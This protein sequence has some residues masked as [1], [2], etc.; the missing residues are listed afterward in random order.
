MSNNH[1]HHAVRIYLLFL[2]LLFP[3]TAFTQTPPPAPA[4]QTPGNLQTQSDAE[5]RR[6]QER[7]M[8]ERKRLEAAPNVHLPR[9]AAPPR[10]PRRLPRDEAPCF[11]IVQ[12]V[13][14]GDE[15]ER[16]SW[17]LNHLGGPDNADAPLGRCL[18][19][20]GI[21]IVTERAQNALIAA[22]FVT[23]RILTAPQDIASGTLTLTLLPGRV[24]VIRLNDASSP[25]ATLW[26]AVPINPGDILNLRDIEQGLENFKRAPTVDA[27][28]KI[29]PASGA[30]PGWS[31]LIILFQQ[32]N[33][34]RFSLTVDDS[35]GKTTGKYQGSATFSVDNWLTLNDLFYIT[36]SQNLGNT[37]A[38]QQ[39]GSR[40]TV[41]HYSLPL[42]YWL[43]A[44]T[45]NTGGY[46]QNVAGATQTYVY[47]GSSAN[48]EV[49]VSRIVWRDAAGKTTASLKAFQRKS[50]NYIDDTEVEVQRRVVG[51][52]EAG[53]AQ[54]QSFGAATLDA[55]LS[56]KHGTGA[57][58]AQP[59]PEEVF[60]EGTAH[61]ALVSGSAIFTAPLQAW[62]QNG[63]L[64]SEWRAQLNR[65][66]LTPQDR[67]GIG[68]RFTVR[69]FDGESSLTA[70]R[71]WLV[72]NDLGW[73]LPRCGQ[74][75]YLALD[76]GEVNG[77]SA[78]T[79]LG[80]RMTGMA[81]GLRGSSNR[82][83][84][85]QYEVFV[86]KPL[87]Q[88]DGFKTARHTAGFSLAWSI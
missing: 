18:G 55:S 17:L 43:F 24:R 6:Q 14:S 77:P 52:W 37:A 44:L 36:G 82:W 41:L 2:V 10:P 23:S 59:A 50:N 1:R 87:R 75:A 28:I 69:G 67:F 54:R 47:S 74:E 80:R 88:P 78:A 63:R 49:K 26:N 56:Y 29:E 51:G 30:G 76:H 58:G 25:R 65:T 53:L 61:F 20:T 81:L 62:A 12:V 13:L 42:G 32:P 73:T 15:H 71:G 33:P 86:G 22:G 7:E 46:Y 21:G 84:S 3:F 11:K 83:G 38:G 8:E 66:A 70:E 79:L 16:F 31:D 72:R 48:N 45:S 57:F 85:A 5:F 27:D 68:G 4:P 19:A 9:E 64:M 40:G 60:G 39:G 35:G 34:F